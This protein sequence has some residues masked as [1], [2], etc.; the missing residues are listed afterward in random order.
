[1]NSFGRVFRISLFGESHGPGVGVVIDGCPPGLALDTADFAADLARRRGGRPGTTA[2]A[3][4]DTPEFLGGLY[5]GRCSGAPLTVFLRHHDVDSSDYERRAAVPRPGHADWTGWV[6]YRG[7]ND[8]RGGGHFSGRLTAA[9]V[10]AGVVAKKIIAPAEVR[11]EILEIHGSRDFTAAIEA[12]QRDGDSVGGIVECRVNGLPAGLGEPFFDTLESQLAHIVLAVPGIKGIEFGAGF[13]AARMLGS[14]CND[15][16]LD[17]SGRTATNHSGGCN[18][19]IGN[20]NELVFRAA[21]RPTPSIA[22][23]QRSIDLA[24]GRPCD[25]QIGGRHDACFALRLPPVLEAAAAVV[26]ADFL[27]LENGRR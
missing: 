6:K 13:A 5:Q 9:L 20:G 19:G 11:A 12:A 21:A 26:L 18:G 14:E 25:T 2:R 1:M 7:C 23:V 27:L 17:A 16:I 8:P 4:A 24:D 22:R 3:E 10:A 15:V